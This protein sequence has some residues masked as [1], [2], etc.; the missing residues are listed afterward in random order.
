M[1]YQHDEDARREADFHRISDYDADRLRALCIGKLRDLGD[2]GLRSHATVFSAA[3]WRGLPGLPDALLARGRV[4]RGDVLDIGKRVLARDLSPVVLLAASFAW[5]TGM[6]GYGPSRYREIVDTAGPALEPS[7][8]QALGAARSGHR[9]PNPV[10]G[11]AQLY[12]GYDPGRRAHPGQEPWSRLHRLGPAFFTKFLYF[13]IPGAL[14]LDNRV[15]NAVHERSRLSHL[16]TAHHRSVARTPYRYA[17]YL[18]WMRQTAQ[19]V[20]VRPEMLELTL[21]QPPA[22]PMAGQ[23]VDE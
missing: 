7:L 11:Y 13:A 6:T 9:S 14:I 10:A 2:G 3:A 15:A 20:G 16:I 1:S 18:H 12:G 4:S 19:T 21:F 5:G 23:G 8:W 22:D 17:V